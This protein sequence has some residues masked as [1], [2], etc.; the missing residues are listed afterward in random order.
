MSQTH[1][2]LSYVIWIV[3]CN[4]NIGR[5]PGPKWVSSQR[6]LEG[7][8][9]TDFANP[10][11]LKGISS[12]SNIVSLDLVPQRS[13]P[14]SRWQGGWRH[15]HFLPSSKLHRKASG[16]LLRPEAVLT[17][18]HLFWTTPLWERI[19]EKIPNGITESQSSCWSAALF[20]GLMGKLPLSA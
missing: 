20:S 15:A 14:W 13:I 19:W 11:V 8:I 4:I 18:Q 12:L 10:P 17:L 7:F 9:C 1:F 5:T 6:N 3:L 16:K 2:W